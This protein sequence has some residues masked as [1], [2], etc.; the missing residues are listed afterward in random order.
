MLVRRNAAAKITIASSESV[1]P[2]M[3]NGMCIPFHPARSRGTLGKE[4]DDVVILV[5][6]FMRREGKSDELEHVA[7]SHLAIS[8]SH[9]MKTR[10]IRFILSTYSIQKGYSE[11]VSMLCEKDEPCCG[12]MRKNYAVDSIEI[13]SPS[14]EWYSN[15]RYLILFPRS[16][17]VK[18]E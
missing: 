6:S 14:A 16:Q 3:P 18:K 13:I 17:S 12:I 8:P 2:F 4:C 10:K 1:V 9:F 11:I 7:S 5:R 15:K